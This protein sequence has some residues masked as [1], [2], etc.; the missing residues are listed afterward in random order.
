MVRSN[1]HQRLSLAPFRGITHKVFRNA[2]ATHIGGI[3][4]YYAPFISGTGRTRINESKLSDI[5]PANENKAPCVPQYIG[6][7]PFE[8]VLLASVLYDI[9]Y[10]EMNWNLGCPFGRIANKKRGCGLLPWPGEI[11]NILERFFHTSKLELSVKTRLGFRSS[12]EFTDVIEVLNKYPLK[13]IIIHPRTGV[14]VYGGK[15]DPEQYLQYKKRCVHPV[16]YN[17]DIFNIAQYKKLT[18]ILPGQNEWMLGRGALI[19]PFLALEIKGM[20]PKPSA[21]REQLRRFHDQ[22]WSYCLE[23][24]PEQR[25]RTGWM[26]AIWHYMSGV[27]ADSTSIFNEI[28]RSGSDKSYL[29]AAGRAFEKEFASDKLIAAHFQRLTS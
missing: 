13:N 11:D 4:L 6:N 9:G 28:K 23:S 14:Q 2:F 15:A 12:D 20:A 21:K 8:M 17:G 19:N 18:E 16:I 24:M 5:I 3:D 25:K 27:F 22:L 26:K 7:D 1:H 29:E 10:K